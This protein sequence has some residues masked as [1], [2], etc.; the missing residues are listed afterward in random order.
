MGTLPGFQGKAHEAADFT[1]RPYLTC[2]PFPPAR[3]SP[4]S[5]HD[6]LQKVD[7]GWLLDKTLKRALSAAYFSRTC[8]IASSFFRMCRFSSRL[9][10]TA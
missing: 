10:L 9:S 8:T 3:Q 5:D 1:I 2:Q 4:A 7:Q 6:S